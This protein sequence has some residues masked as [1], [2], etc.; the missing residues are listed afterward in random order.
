MSP[1]DL[2]QKIDQG[3][4][5]TVIDLRNLIALEYQPAR[6]PG[7][8]VMAVEDLESRHEEIPRDQDI[9]LYCT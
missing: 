9:V 5:V 6:I 8:Q 4:D 2:K 3:E 7:A 1:E